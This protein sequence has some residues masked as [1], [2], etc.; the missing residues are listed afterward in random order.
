MNLI[1][2]NPDSKQHIMSIRDFSNEVGK[3]LE[4]ISALKR[5]EK[6][7]ESI[8]SNTIC[9]MAMSMMGQKVQNLAIIQGTRDNRLIELTIINQK[10]GDN[11]KN[12]D[13]IKKTTDYSF[14]QLNAETI[15]I[16][17][18]HQDKALEAL[19]YES[20]GNDPG[21]IPYIKDREKTVGIGMKRV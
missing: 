6:E 18:N 1:I 9:E 4:I 8:N 10:D 12:R 11:E 20:L 7:S 19:G 16:F 21:M 3:E 15:V 13:F 5:V 17:S 2:V 14:N